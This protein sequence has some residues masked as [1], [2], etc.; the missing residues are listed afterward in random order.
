MEERMVKM[1]KYPFSENGIRFFLSDVFQSAWKLCG[2]EYKAQSATSAIS[3]Y[4][5]TGRAPTDF[6]RSML[7]HRPS[8]IAKRCLA[9]G[10]DQEIIDRVKKLVSVW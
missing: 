9:G 8:T 2:S 3:W 5:N 10:S 6:V 4:V 1:E 7:K